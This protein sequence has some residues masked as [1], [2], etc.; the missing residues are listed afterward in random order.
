MIA[1]LGYLFFVFFLRNNMMISMI[2]PFRPNDRNGAD[3]LCLTSMIV[4]DTKPI[5]LK[6]QY[7]RTV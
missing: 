3:R 5:R 6:K 4:L 7:L 1:T 2:E